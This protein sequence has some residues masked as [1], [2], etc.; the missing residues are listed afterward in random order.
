MCRRG[1]I[2]RIN[3][4]ISEDGIEM[5]RHS[6]IVIEDEGG[7]I[8]GLSYDL[9]ASVMSSIKNERHKQ[10]KLKY[11]ENILITQN[12]RS[13][14][15]ENGKEA[16]IKAD[17]LYYFKKSKITYTV[18]GYATDAIMDTIYEIIEIL[19]KDEK[20]KINIKNIA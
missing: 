11:I 15:P 4:Y 8:S 10:K 16:Y 20:L 13:C 19:D 12:D 6:F 1:D 5:S 2:I 17:Q 9:V 18:M 14:S 7:T 3:S